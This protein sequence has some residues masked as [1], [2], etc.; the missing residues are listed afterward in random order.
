MNEWL[1]NIGQ[2]IITEK[3][4]YSREIPTACVTL[5]TT[6][7]LWTGLKS[8]PGL[9]PDRSL[10]QCKPIWTRCRPQESATNKP[11]P[12]TSN[13]KRCTA[14]QTSR[15][16]HCVPQ[17]IRF[18][19]RRTG[20]KFDLFYR[21]VSLLILQQHCIPHQSI[22]TY[23]N[24]VYGKSCLSYEQKTWLTWIQYLPPLLSSHQQLRRH[25]G[26]VITVTFL[27]QLRW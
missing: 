17:G 1:W 27:C 15:S 21:F 5:S 8:S 16:S 2:I 6:N 20:T 4:T 7:P 22:K 26:L 11:V 3:S 24:Y 10:T 18:I 13:L 23:Y 19:I 9:C 25:Q 14:L 12:S